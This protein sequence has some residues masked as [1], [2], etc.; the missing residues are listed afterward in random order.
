MQCMSIASN[1]LHLL[2]N[3]VLLVGLA[4]HGIASKRLHLSNPMCSVSGTL[5]SLFLIPNSSF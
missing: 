3:K 1:R 2:Y 4:S 5:Y